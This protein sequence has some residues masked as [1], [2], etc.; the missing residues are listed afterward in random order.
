M[1]LQTIRLVAYWIKKT[2]FSVLSFLA[3]PHLTFQGKFT[4][5]TFSAWGISI[6]KISAIFWRSDVRKVVFCIRFYFIRFCLIMPIMAKIL[7]PFVTTNLQFIVN[8]LQHRF[9]FNFFKEIMFQKFYCYK[10][11]IIIDL[12]TINKAK[13]TLG[14]TNLEFICIILHIYDEL[15]RICDWFIRCDL[16]IVKFKNLSKLHFFK[17]VV[18]LKLPLI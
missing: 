12:L 16:S 7:Y 4:T 14:T 1:V 9:K 17:E 2:G 10:S 8:K 13:K 11:P 3:E 5:S 15:F 18:F 6:S